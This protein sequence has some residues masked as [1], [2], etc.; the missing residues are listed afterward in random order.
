ML[1]GMPFGNQTWLAGKSSIN[2]GFYSNINYSIYNKWW[3]Y[4]VAIIRLNIYVPEYSLEYIP[5]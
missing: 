1:N 3:I 2:R 5:L 4:Y